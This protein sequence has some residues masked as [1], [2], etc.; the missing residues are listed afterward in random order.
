MAHFDQ[1][2]PGA[3][4]PAGQRGRTPGRFAV[5]RISPRVDP[6]K[7]RYPKR[8]CVDGAAAS[9]LGLLSEPA[10]AAQVRKP[11][12]RTNCRA[13]AQDQAPKTSAHGY[14]QS[15]AVLARP[16]GANRLRR[17]T[18]PIAENRPSRSSASAT[19]SGPRPAPPRGVC[20]A[21]ARAGKT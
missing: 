5:V 17:T 13:D 10:R 16:G 1:V 15:E 7:S 19:S 8:C 6:T 20:D 2:G 12:S 4:Q 18:R 14:R 9:A 11:A 3:E 21:I